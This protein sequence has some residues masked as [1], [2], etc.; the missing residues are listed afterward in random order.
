MIAVALLLL[1]GL[2]FLLTAETRGAVKLS[3]GTLTISGGST[4]GDAP[5]LTSVRGRTAR[6]QMP[7]GY[8]QVTIERLVK[9]RPAKWATF[10]LATAP[11]AGG[12]VTIK[13]RKAVSKR[14][15][16]VVGRKAAPVV[17]AGNPSIFTPPG[18]L[19]VNDSLPTLI[20]G[21]GGL[22]LAGDSSTN[23]TATINRDVVES[24]IWKLHGDRLY[25]FNPYR[26]LQVLDLANPAAPVLLGTLDLPDAGEALYLVG[27]D[28][29][30]LL[31]KRDVNFT[32]TNVPQMTGSLV[33]CD[34]AAGKPKTVATIPLDG[35]LVESR[36]VGT[37]LYV[38]TS[39]RSGTST[40]E[41]I[42]VTGFD[43]SNPANPVARN[44]V[45][46]PLLIGGYSSQGPVQAS[47]HYFL[48]AQHRREVLSSNGY[49]SRVSLV[50]ISS[51]DGSVALRG[52]AI[53]AGMVSDKFKMQERNGILSLVSNVSQL[54]NTKLENFDL[55]NA[56]APAL[57]G[58]LTLGQNETVRGTRFDGDRVYVV[59]F[60]QIDPL[61]IIDNSAP[62][63]PALVG[64]LEVPGFSTYIEPMGDR[65]VTIGLVNNRVSVSL[66]DV[67]D[68]TNPSLLSQLPVSDA[69]TWS[70][71]TWNEKAFSVNPEAGLIM[72]PLTTNWSNWLWNPSST[73]NG[74]IQLVDLERQQ[75]RM[76]GRIDRNFTPRRSEFHR[77][78]IVAISNEDLL[79]ADTTD[80]DHPAVLAEVQLAWKTLQAWPI[81]KY[82]LQITADLSGANPVITVAP[83]NNPDGAISSVNLT[84]ET[85]IATDL[86]DDLLYVVQA[87]VQPGVRVAPPTTTLTIFD[88][89][90]L[91]HVVQKGAVTLSGSAVQFAEHRILW[92]QPGTMVL[93][94]SDQG[95]YGWFQPI[96]FIGDLP[97]IASPL[98]NTTRASIG[99]TLTLANTATTSLA[100]S[101]LIYNGY[102]TIYRKRL[103]AFD[104]TDPTNPVFL[105]ETMLYPKALGRFDELFAGG[106]KIF[107]SAR[108]EYPVTTF[109][110]VDVASTGASISTKP[111]LE[112][113]KSYLH[114]VDYTD[115][116]NPL[117]KAPISSP[118]EL[119]GVSRNGTVLFTQ[120][121]EYDNTGTGISTRQLSV[122][123]SIYDGTKLELASQL[124]LPRGTRSLIDGETV[125]TF[126]NKA[127]PETDGKLAS[128]VSLWDVQPELQFVERDSIRFGGYNERVID[129]VLLSTTFLTSGSAVSAVDFS[130]HADLKYLGWISTPYSNNELSRATGDRTNGIWIPLG[131]YGVLKLELPA[132]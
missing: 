57:L 17:A 72:V 24:D 107:A 80:R 123:A 105:N 2:L 35:K 51:P 104:V 85:V 132:P 21:G 6:V 29:V 103:Q 81:G 127:T 44:T 101:G 61:W 53:A 73:T 15:L 99:G 95:S 37:A 12:E 62:K 86:R 109:V 69:W 33:I 5:T 60:L 16:R 77:G 112:F 48:V 110:M 63:A 88:V 49:R 67:A 23:G 54:R 129:R 25:V 83:T 20:E 122:H 102:P 30:A 119:K 66:F 87:P 124:S 113:G 71:A 78:T 82:L 28:H 42:S 45:T 115:P 59:T 94:I 55:T 89:S 19:T 97:I 93:T 68:P 121:W 64:H 22:T 8:D 117:V 36:L 7:A 111:D 38:A 108:I 34:V 114:V 13:L 84:P 32:W 91:P 70:E 130:D 96:F 46:V 18:D 39:N 98:L 47:D 100:T 125:F 120:G 52:T 74:G 75:L 3:S 4:I 26:G 131:D 58:S 118:G 106:G 43:L 40:S 14:F 90:S 76:R 128:Y 116:A 50:D 65:L 27:N 41:E 11:I 1:I 9:V 56:N 10:A 126:Y 79:T 92:P 31:T